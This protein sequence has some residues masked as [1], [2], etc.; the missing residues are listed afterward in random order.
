MRIRLVIVAAA[1]CCV[2][3]VA[4]VRTP[5]EAPQVGARPLSSDARAD[6]PVRRIELLRA[7]RFDDVS[8]F[9]DDDIARIDSWLA[10]QVE[11]AKYPSLSVA[12]VRDG[13]VKYRRSFGFRDIAGEKRA[14]PETPYHIASVTKVF[15][16]LLAVQLHNRGVVDLDAPVTKYLPEGVVI[17]TNPKAGATITL[18]HLASHTSGL[19]RSV[20]GKVQSIEGRYQLE[21]KL[22]YAHLANV[23][24]EFEPGTKEL[25]SNLGMGLLGHVLE[26]A[27]A[28]PF[29]E[30]LKELVCEP[31]R[32][33][34]TA[35]SDSSRRF[36]A[37]G[38]S[39]GIPRLPAD[40]SRME[41]LVSS[42][43]LVSS[44]EDL[45]RFL[46]ANM[47]PGFVSDETL[48]QLHTPTKLSSG[49]LARTGLGWSVRTRPSIGQ[50]LK[51]NGGRNN[52]SAWI[53]FA[54]EHGVGVTVVTNC[55][56]P[57]VDSIGYWLLERSV[58]GVASDLLAREP[59]ERSIY[60]RVAPFTG[61][62][63]ENEKPIVCV[64]DRWSP[65]VSID[66]IPIER[67]VA[68]A[69]KKFRDK[70]RKRF[71]ED[72]VEVLSAMG[73]EPKWTVTL[74]IVASDGTVKKVPVRMTEHNR[75]L[76]R[77]QLIPA[78]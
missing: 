1:A 23:S 34:N 62:R 31:L 4:F 66:E 63:W 75:N 26:R 2:G 9:E 56:D 58:P 27:A 68:F 3:A 43:G 20:P 38:Y 5:C 72:L 32:L 42:G 21:Q 46:I 53:G 41:R 54:P 22:L 16:T 14:S 24:L 7:P 44:T 59:V 73:Y 29:D 47:K 71:A 48:A 55:G 77:R 78:Q 60:A 13:D 28:K 11:R 36:T 64:Q 12:I 8:A 65:V 52:C 61:V 10:A 70:A 6:S 49:S 39:N 69:R 76:V 50:V 15:T 40:Y 30:L 17:T 51:K 35:V 45:T 67:V 57:D 33:A 74:G 37:I 19:P 18:R 25:Y